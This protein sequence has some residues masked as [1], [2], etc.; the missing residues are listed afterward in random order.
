MDIFEEFH[1]VIVALHG[2][3]RLPLI[4]QLGG[5][6][7]LEEAIKPELADSRFRLRLRDFGGTKGKG[8]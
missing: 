2:G 5:S 4:G 3:K 7:H 8:G 6:R 1:R